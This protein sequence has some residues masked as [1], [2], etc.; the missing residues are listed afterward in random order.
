MLGSEASFGEAEAPQE[1]C[2]QGS[3]KSRTSE[4]QSGKPLS[5]GARNPK[6]W[7]MWQEKVWRACGPT[8][9]ESIIQLSL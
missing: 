4:A 2:G 3:C 6:A 9:W 5:L 8:L 7:V 1:A